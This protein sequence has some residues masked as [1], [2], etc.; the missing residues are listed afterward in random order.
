[1]ARGMTADAG[2]RRFRRVPLEN[3]FNNLYE[4]AP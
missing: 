2:F 3:P 4:V 1:V